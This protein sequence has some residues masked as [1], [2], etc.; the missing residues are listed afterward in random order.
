M[1]TCKLVGTPIVLVLILTGLDSAEALSLAS[2]DFTLNVYALF[3]T[4]S[5]IVVEVAPTLYV[6]PFVLLV[7][8]YA[9]A[10]CLPSNRLV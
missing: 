3:G 1:L 9:L 2:R 7:R 6:F 8:R 10:P 4:K 5:E